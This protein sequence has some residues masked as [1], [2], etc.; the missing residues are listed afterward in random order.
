MIEINREYRRNAVTEQTFEN[1]FIEGNLKE[2]LTLK[3]FETFSRSR[4]KDTLV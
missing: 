2:F 1:S 3:F 4:V